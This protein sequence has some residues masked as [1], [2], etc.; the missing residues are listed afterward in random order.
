MAIP[1]TE[2]FECIPYTEE[3][4]EDIFRQACQNHGITMSGNNKGVYQNE[5]YGI[6]IEVTL[7]PTFNNAYTY[8]RVEHRPQKYDDVSNSFVQN[9]VFLKRLVVPTE[10]LDS[11]L[12]LIGMDIISS[13]VRIVK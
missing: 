12:E 3:E 10:L 2:I 8:T 5:T 1:L 11:R 4:Y 7:L 6:K 13:A 9:E